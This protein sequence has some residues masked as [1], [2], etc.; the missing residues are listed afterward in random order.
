M[1]P[2][3][4]NLQRRYF[5]LQAPI[6]GSCAILIA[7]CLITPSVLRQRRR[8]QEQK[9]A[10]TLGVNADDYRLFP[11]D[12][13]VK[14]LQPG[15]NPGVSMEMV[16]VTVLGYA[17]VVQCHDASLRPREVYYFYSRSDTEALRLEFNYDEVWRLTNIRGEDDDS[18]G[19]FIEG[20]IPGRLSEVSE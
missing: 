9:L 4:R 7:L 13:F 3:E 12:Y 11:Y 20:C 15:R 8:D 18:G 10:A 2:Y 1:T 14:K 5:V 17:R 16:H 6:V 19:I